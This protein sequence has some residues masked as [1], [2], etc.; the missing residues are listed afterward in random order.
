MR[1][2]PR[3][4]ADGLLGVRRFDSPRCAHVTM[5]DAVPKLLDLM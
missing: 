1:L 5:K 4:M 2:N 3:E